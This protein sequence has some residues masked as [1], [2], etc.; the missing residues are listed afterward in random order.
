MARQTKRYSV[1]PYPSLFS[2]EEL[3]SNEIEEVSPEA[4]RQSP[5]VRFMSMGSGSSGNCAFLTDGKT[6]III[7]AGVDPL[8]IKPMLER[9]GYSLKNVS[10]IL[11]TH[12]HGDHVRYVYK[13]VSA[14]PAM[15]VYCTP[16]TFNGIM[17]RHNIAR[18][19]KDYF[20]A[21]YKEFP[22]NIGKW[23]VTAFDVSHD[24]SDNVGFFLANGAHRMAVATDLGCITERVR[25]YMGLAQ[26]IVIESNY[27][28]L[29]LA[30]GP[31]PEFL[32]ARIA[33][34]RGH[35]DN[36]VSAGFIRELYESS[37]ILRRVFLCHLSHDN[38]T[39]AMAL[40]SVESTL[41]AADP[42]IEIVRDDTL[43]QADKSRRRILVDVLP[44]FE[45]SLLH[46]F[47]LDI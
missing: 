10:G 17:R 9:H 5:A 27:D 1:S 44:R 25:H 38:N 42:T 16:K 12:D 43:P 19:L 33:A 36:E 30:R 41:R 6:A 47:R 35:L 3:D 32:K 46:T 23:E 40:A 29:M 31:Y 18:R 15:K 20:Q 21:I 34:E 8:K 2:A 14:N 22:F 13:L 37:T 26:S 45:A 28:S 11:L 39:P 4:M 24:G 7:D